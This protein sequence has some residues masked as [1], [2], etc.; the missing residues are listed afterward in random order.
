MYIEVCYY[1]FLK[2]KISGVSKM[3]QEGMALTTKHGNLDSVSW[4]LSVEW[5][6]WLFQVALCPSHT[7]SGTHACACVRVHTYFEKNKSKEKFI[8][9]N[10]LKIK[11]AGR[12]RYKWGD[13]HCICLL[14]KHFLS[15]NLSLMSQM[16]TD[17]P[18]PVLVECSPPT[19]VIACLLVCTPLQ[20]T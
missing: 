8:V 7:H 10:I 5:D 1:T 11:E 17:T 16:E 12:K 3:I 20:R 6:N 14:G 18:T 9:L 13:L 4:T 2:I 15:R 19:V